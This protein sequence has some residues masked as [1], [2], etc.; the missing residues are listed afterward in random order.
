MNIAAGVTTASLIL[1]APH[2]MAAGRA[3]IR[4]T[5]VRQTHNLDCEAAALQV[6][7]AA[8][9]INVTQDSILGNMGDDRRLP[10]GPTGRPSHWGNP[11]T[12]FVG[13]VNGR[14][15]VTGYGVYGP[16]IAAAAHAEGAA[17]TAQEGVAPSA[18]YA[19]VAS[20]TPVVV[21]VPHL[22]VAPS[23]GQ[24]TAWDGTPVWYSPQEHAQTLVGFD[25]SAG[26]VTLADPWDGQLHTFSMSLFQ[27]RF[28]AFHDTAVF[29]APPDG[30]SASVTS[31]GGGQAIFWKGAV[32]RLWE[33]QNDGGGWSSSTQVNPPAGPV[34][35]APSTS[36]TAAGQQIVFWQ[37]TD[38]FLHEMWSQSGTWNGPVLVETTTWMASPPAVAV[39]PDNQQAVFWES[40]GGY[41]QEM[42]FGGGH[43]NGPVAVPGASGMSSAPGV[44]VTPSNEQAVFWKSS[45]GNLTEIWWTPADR[46][47]HGPVDVTTSAS[48]GSG[49][50]A[51]VVPTGQ[52]VV[53]WQ[54]GSGALQET[55]WTPGSGWSG[56]ATWGFAAL[57]STPSVDVD[58]AGRQTVFWKGADANVWM[59]QWTSGGWSAPADLQAGPIH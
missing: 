38:A 41:L 6:A 35:S 23:L 4:V 16:P 37:G 3:S 13:D 47:W 52:Q 58:P 44:L 10:L 51:A 21:W 28:A 24:W 32:D 20:G 5:P 43:W 22:L 27:S 49:P 34:A 9:G 19:A 55:W 30:P 8:I 11:D 17:A 46:H 50:S 56:T 2:A 1:V 33:A 29:V 54:G 18:L 12:G 31:A 7:L 25:M 36:V 42:W 59:G 57:F 45:N 15:L 53:F 26:T 40:P 39:T 14:M 48:M